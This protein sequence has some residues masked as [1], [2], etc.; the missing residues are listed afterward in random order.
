MCAKVSHHQEILKF[1]FSLFFSYPDLLRLFRLFTRILGKNN[2]VLMDWLK[3]VR[4]CMRRYFPE[5]VNKIE[6]C[7]DPTTYFEVRGVFYVNFSR[8]REAQRQSINK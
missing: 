7:E 4:D 2:D 3:M 8:H 5:E 6:N 1:Y